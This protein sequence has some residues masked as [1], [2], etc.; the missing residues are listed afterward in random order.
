MEKKIDFLFALL[1]SSAKIFNAI[2]VLPVPGPPFT[3]TIFF[4]FLFFLL[5]IHD[6]IVFFATICS[7]NKAKV[8]S[9]FIIFEAFSSNFFDGVIG[10]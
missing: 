1:A 3:I 4:L 9:L 2:T 8:E 6:K 7:S 10:L 5:F